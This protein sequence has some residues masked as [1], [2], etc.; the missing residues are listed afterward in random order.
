VSDKYRFGSV[1]ACLAATGEV[2]LADDR[3]R[4]FSAGAL[5]TVSVANG[6]P[7]NDIPGFGIQ[8]RYALSD[9]WALGATLLQSEYDFETPAQIAGITQSPAIEPVDA[10]AESTMLQAWAERLFH[11]GGGAT[12]WFVG[13]GLGAASVDVPDVSGAREDGGQFD[14]HTEVDTEIML[15]AFAG[16]RRSFGDRWYGE[17]RAHANHHFADWQVEDRISGNTGAIDDYNSFGGHVAVGVRW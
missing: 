14:V 9:R 7:A 5:V 6:E 10:L 12:T 15:T 4:G 11:P 2:A 8:F 16:V 17:F 13:A 3:E 1:I